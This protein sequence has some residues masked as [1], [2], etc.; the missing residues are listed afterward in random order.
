[1]EILGFCLTTA[2]E[3]IPK[4]NTG[5]IVLTREDYKHFRIQRGDTEGI[6]NYILKVR[7]LK[8]AALISERDGFVKL[9]LR[10]IGDFSVQ[11]IATAHFGG[12]G[13]KNASGGFSK[14]SFRDTVNKFKDVLPSYKA[15]LEDPY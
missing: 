8:V 14:M 3:I 10:S 5:M 6:V 15:Q 12:G 13:H 11:E 4:Y 2:L 9:A 1:M 7:R